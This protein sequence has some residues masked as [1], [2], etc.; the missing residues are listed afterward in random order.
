VMYDLE[1]VAN[2]LTELGVEQVEVRWDEIYACCPGHLENLGRPDYN[3][4][5]HMNAEGIHNCWSCHYSGNL[6]SLVIERL[7]L[8]T[9]WG[10]PDYATA[11]AWIEEHVGDYLTGAADRLESDP[12]WV[13]PPKPV[14]MT[15]AR[16]AVFSEPPDYA[17]RKRGIS[18]EIAREYQ[19]LWHQANKWWITPL[20]HPIT[21]ALMGWQEKGQHSRY[22]KNRP[23]TMKKSSTFFGLQHAFNRRDTVVVV[24]SPLDAG[25]IMTVWDQGASIATCG[26]KIS[27]KQMAIMR[28]FDYVVWAFDNDGPGHDANRTVLANGLRGAFFNYGTTGAKDPGEM[29]A[30]EIRRGIITSR[31][32]VRGE[33]AWA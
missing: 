4:S 15:E 14:P 24:E 9:R 23:P 3:P 26:A 6:V 10:L 20:R 28:E 29:T 17:L 33:A 16:L 21:N 2:A 8:T 22:F 12:L 31:S 13:A 7:D 19:I 25:R 32:S 5:W 27:K 18:A 1:C 30:E 11:E